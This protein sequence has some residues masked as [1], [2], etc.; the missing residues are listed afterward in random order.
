MSLKLPSL[1]VKGFLFSIFF[2]FLA[3]TGPSPSQAACG[4]YFSCNQEI[5]R[6]KKE[7][8][9]LK[10][11][12]NTLA[13]QIAYL[14]N[15]IYLTELEIQAKEEEITLLNGDIGNLST[16]LER[17][18]SFLQFQ[19]RIFV[20]RARSA[21]ISDQLSS[22]DIVLGAENLD[23]AIRRIRYLRVLEEKDLEALEEMKETRVSFNGQKTT[24]ETK[25]SDVEKLKAEVEAKKRSL[26]RQQNSKRQLLEE[27]RGEE[28]RYQNML[29]LL[30][31]ERAAIIRA[32][33]QRGV[34]LGK[35][36]KGQAIAKQG[37]TGCSTGSHIHYSIHKTSNLYT[38]YNPYNYLGVSAPSSCISGFPM[39][40]VV[41]GSFNRPAGSCN[42]LTQDYWWAH[43]AFDIVSADGWVYASDDGEAYLVKDDPSFAAVCR[44]WGYP[45]N[46][47]GYGIRIDHPNG[48][49]TSYWHI[50]P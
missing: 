13:N 16:R 6:V 49:T 42:K 24:L 40:L 23:G 22:F 1:L 19:E 36:K 47:T 43:T 7:I 21:Y 30:E 28:A 18:G 46:G 5:E 20:V 39:G 4:D 31:A 11:L 27:T 8:S 33:S 12:A 35:V 25:K 14:T 45:Y 41:S 26:V 29:K 32:L 48:I 10:G 37:S 17:I 44:S 3:S 34:S 50:Q 2:L 15:Q 38:T 9:R